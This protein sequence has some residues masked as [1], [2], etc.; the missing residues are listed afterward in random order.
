MVD[1]MR[2]EHSMSIRAACRAINISRTVYHYRPDTYKDQPV[3]EVLLELVDRY[4]RYGFG[5]LF[6]LIRRQ[7]HSWNHKRVHRVYCTLKLNIRRKGKKRLPNR[8]PEPLRVP[9]SINQCWSADFMSDAL[10]HGRRF[11]TFNVVDDFNREVLSIEIDFNL[12]AKRIIRTLD[13]IALW[14]GYPAKLRVDNGPEFTSVLMA[15]WAE[16]HGVTLEFI[17]PGKPTQNSFIER[18]N[19]TYREEVL[20]MYIFK[21]L[22]EVRNTTEN[23]IDE[24]NEQRPHES[25]GNLTPREYM[26]INNQQPDSTFTWH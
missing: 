20:D 2:Q 17:Q 18:F 23:W 1:L 22:S 15:E 8:Y 4:P 12:Q 13:R 9:E 7:G 21:R 19:R 25:L 16:T 14:R 24:Y 5:K 11:R 10:W 26:I 3:I 6:P